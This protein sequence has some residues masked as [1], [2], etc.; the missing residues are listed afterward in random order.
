MDR[1]QVAE[2]ANADME[3]SQMVFTRPFSI[4]SYG[5]GRGGGPL[6]V[7][8]ASAAAAAA[9]A[10]K[11]ESGAGTC[12]ALVPA[13]ALAAVELSDVPSATDPLPAATGIAEEIPVPR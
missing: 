13:A 1:R 11:S 12:A 4:A 8:A 7:A 2:Q 6:D 3:Q 10:A 9:A 5:S